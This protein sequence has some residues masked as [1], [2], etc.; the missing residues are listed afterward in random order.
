MRR[1]LNAISSE[2]MISR[3]NHCEVLGTEADSHICRIRLDKFNNSFKYAEAQF[4]SGD[5][6]CVKSLRIRSFSAPYFPAFRLNMDW[7]SLRIQSECGKIRT[8]KT[9][10]AD[11]FHSVTVQD[12]KHYIVPSLFTHKP[13]V[14]VVHICLNNVI[15][16][17]NESIEL[18]RITEEI[19][20]LS[21]NCKQYLWMIWLFHLLLLRRTWIY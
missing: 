6:H 2:K 5:T 13:D 21:I 19:L 8:R 15:N 17:N 14:A 3:R 20:E 7:V 16:R 11:T 10:N 12:M 1:S 9:P 18:N 4:F